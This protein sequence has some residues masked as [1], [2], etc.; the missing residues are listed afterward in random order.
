MQP[1]VLFDLDGTLV[2]SEE[3]IFKSIEYALGKMHYEGFENLELRKFIGP[4]LFDSFTRYCHM[5]SDD[6]N[7][8]VAYY[9]ERYSVTGM[10]E[11]ELYPGVPAMLE[12]LAAEGF[13]LTIASSK[14]EHYVE[15]IVEHFGIAGAFEQI[16]GA[17]M[18]ASRSSKEFVIAEALCRLGA[19]PATGGIVMVGDKEHDIFG[20][21]A[22]GIPCIAVT[23]GY[24]TAEEFDAARPAARVDSPAEIAEAV[25]ALTR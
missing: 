11:G 24:G 18:D 21:R 15:R 19:D 20:A 12:A 6:A 17:S 3:G 2:K 14:P 25:Q 10:F 13:T 9:R 22:H 23:Y 7:K 8:T 5:T 4:P 16:V 1:I